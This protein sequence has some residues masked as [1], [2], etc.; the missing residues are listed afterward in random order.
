M[1][2]ATPTQARSGRSPRDIA[3]SLLV[4]LV[5]VVLLLGIYR[6]VF[7]GDAPIAA[8]NEADTWATARHAMPTIRVFQ[9]VGY[10]PDSPGRGRRDPSCP[11]HQRPPEHC[12]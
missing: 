6:L 5:P 12:C 9:A 10:V 3:L 1:S 11:A 4:L 8:A 2:D 7:S